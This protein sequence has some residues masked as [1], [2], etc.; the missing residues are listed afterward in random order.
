[1]SKNS[2]II[3][4][5]RL[6][7]G[8][9]E[10]SIEEGCS[11]KEFRKIEKLLDSVKIF[12]EKDNDVLEVANDYILMDRDHLFLVNKVSAAAN[13]KCLG[14][15]WKINNNDPDPFPSN[16]HAHDIENGDKLDLYTGN[17]YNKFGKSIGKIKTKSLKVFLEELSRRGCYQNKADEILKSIQGDGA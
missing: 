8:E 9:A 12:K 5:S 15:I 2:I 14:R 3:K 11:I 6:G 17:R 13:I 7:C 1:M 4:T 16:F 10:L